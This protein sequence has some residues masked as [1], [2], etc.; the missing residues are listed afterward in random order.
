MDGDRRQESA[1]EWVG[2]EDRNQQ[3]SGWGQEK[4]TAEEWVETGGRNLV[5]RGVG[6]VGKTGNERGSG[7]QEK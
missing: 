3:R 6:S 2:I 4:G 7:M 5:E 1:E